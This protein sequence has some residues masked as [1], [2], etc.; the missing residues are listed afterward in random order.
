MSGTFLDVYIYTYRRCVCSG[1][2]SDLPDIVE[3]DLEG[4][5]DTN[6]YLEESWDSQGTS[7]F[8]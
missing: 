5:A 8:K 7:L 3:N 1:L 2:D 6:C 4:R